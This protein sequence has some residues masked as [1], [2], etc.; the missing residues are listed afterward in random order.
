MYIYI[1]ICKYISRHGAVVQLIMHRSTCVRVGVCVYQHHCVWNLVNFKTK[2]LYTRMYTICI[3]V[4]VSMYVCVCVC[5][6]ACTQCEFSV[7]GPP[8][9][10][11]I[12]ECYRA[13]ANTVDRT[14][15]FLFFLYLLYYY[16]KML[17][18][19]PSKVGNTN[20]LYCAGGPCV[21]PLIF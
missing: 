20:S 2:N 15:P 12:C 16:L 1:C 8:H 10:C 18:R 6:R 17:Q 5:L 21:Y 7:W 4:S 9:D 19:S 11:L 13:F 14:K 3:R